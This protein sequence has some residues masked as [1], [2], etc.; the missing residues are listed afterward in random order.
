MTIHMRSVI[1]LVIV[2]LIVKSSILCAQDSTKSSIGLTFKPALIFPKFDS[3]LEISR[4]EKITRREWIPRIDIRNPFAIDTRTSSYYVPRQVRDEL[5][6]IMNRPRESAFMPVL[7]LAAFL[8]SQIAENVLFISLKTSIDAENIL[9]SR[10]NTDILELLW[11]K[12]PRTADELYLEPPF[13][14]EMTC[15]GL[16]DSL[17][18]LI[19]NNLIRTRQEKENTFY[20][21]ALKRDVFILKIKRFLSDRNTGS[22]IRISLEE[23][24]NKLN[25]YNLPYR[26]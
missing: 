11:E 3:L 2:F 16:I 7:G 22:E 12:N 10:N 1:V 5:N 17:N 13:E 8:A 9:R 4:P 19:E 21:P 23:L 15:N 18:V 14:N 26:D 20:F 24:L 25:T 6:L